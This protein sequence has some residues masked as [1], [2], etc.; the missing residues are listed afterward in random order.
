M[1]NKHILSFNDYYGNEFTMVFRE[2][3][4]ALTAIP[5]L[6]WNYQQFKLTTIHYAAHYD[7]K[8]C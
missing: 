4:D 2:V 6:T 7:E 3:V 8:L 1:R 5:F